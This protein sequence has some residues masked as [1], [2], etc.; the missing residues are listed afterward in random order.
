LTQCG[1]PRDELKSEQSDSSRDESGTEHFAFVAGMRVQALLWIRLSLRQLPEREHSAV[2]R[3]VQR[4]RL[5]HPIELQ[6]EHVVIRKVRPG[7]ER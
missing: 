6:P 5:H 1:P 2:R 3:H 7:A 4:A